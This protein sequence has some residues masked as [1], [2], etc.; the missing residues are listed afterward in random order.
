MARPN[1]RCADTFIWGYAHRTSLRQALC[2]FLLA[3][4]ELITN[5]ASALPHSPLPRTAFEISIFSKSYPRINS[6]MSLT[7]PLDLPLLAPPPRFIIHLHRLIRKRERHPLRIIKSLRSRPSKV[8][9]FV[10]HLKS[11]NHCVLLFPLH[12]SSYRIYLYFIP[13]SFIVLSSPYSI[14]TPQLSIPKCPT[15]RLSMYG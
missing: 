6:S 13:Q 12:L 15:S 4:I 5:N 1:Q 3:P 7:V 10:L 14:H 11:P 9:I 8:I 2:V